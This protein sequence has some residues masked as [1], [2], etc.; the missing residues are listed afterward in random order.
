MIVC[1]RPAKFVSDATILDR[2][3]RAAHWAHHRLLDFEDEHQSVIDAAA[4]VA[5]PGITRVGRIL[6]RLRKRARRAQ[7]TP[8]GSW[9]PPLHPELAE[10]LTQRIAALREQRNADPRWKAALGWADEQVGEAKAVRRRRAKPAEKVKR[11]K[12]ETDEAFTKR[13]ALLTSDESDE[14]YQEKLAKAKRDSRRDVRRKQL[15]NQRSCYWGTWNAVI[16]S[17]DDARA[18]V[19]KRR[20]EGFLAEWRRP[21]WDGNRTLRVDAG[22]FRIERGK[23]WWTIEMRVGTGRNADAH[24]VSFRAKCGNWHKMPDDAKIVS[25]ELT[26]RKEGHYRWAYSVSLTIDMAKPRASAAT[27]GSVA[28]DWGHREHGHDRANEGMRVFTWVGDDGRTGEVLLPVA[29]REAL[30]QIDALK[31][32]M[33][34]VFTARGSGEKNRYRYRRQLERLGVRTAEQSAWLAWETRYERRVARLRRR[35]ANVRNETYLSAVREML[36]RYATFVFENEENWSLKKRA[37]DEGTARRKRSNRDMSARHDFVK[38]C[39]RYG[40]A[41]TTV[42][43]RNTTRECPDCGH[44]G[45]NGPELLTACVVCG[46]VRDK[47]YGAARVILKRSQ[48]PLATPEAPA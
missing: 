9:C 15:Y 26:R 44:L 5:A 37:K 13:F 38:I 31:S 46:I 42:P 34:M 33:D 35:L 12:T 4:E 43:S 29:C 3:F 32:R 19:L 24:W 25:C 41:I 27:S 8:E 1:N 36:S 11:R 18:A 21:R 39:E 40:A 7:R 20:K 48:G 45:K 2:E 6:A 28:F 47:D 14:H 17:V 16:E 30:D 10:R 23:L 22:G